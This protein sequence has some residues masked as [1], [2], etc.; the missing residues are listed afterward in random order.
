[1]PFW[2]GRR[3]KPWY[4]RWRRKRR[5]N[6]YKR[7]R[8]RFTRRRNRKTFRR[9]RKRKRKVRRKKKKITI[10]QWQPESIRKCTIKGYSTLVLGAEGRQSFCWTN[11]ASEYIQPKAP[12][13]G[14]FGCEAITLK[15]LYQEERRHNNIWTETNNYKDLCRYT[16]CQIIL[17]RHPT[18]DFV[19]N[20]KISPP[21]DIDKFTYTA[22]QPQNLLLARHHKVILSQKKTPN[23][24]HYVKIKIKCPKLMTTKWFFQR[25][26]CK[27]PLVQLQASAAD[28]GH[29]RIGPLSQSQMITINFLNAQFYPEPNW[30]VALN[31]PWL[32]VA[33]IS[34]PLTVKY[35]NARGETQTMQLGNNWLETQAGYYQSIN[36]NG[37]WFDARLLNAFEIHGRTGQAQGALP[38]AVARYNPNEDTGEG[39]SVYLISLTKDSYK[40]PTATPNYV[41]RGLPLW[42]A[43]FG[44]RDFIQY[45]SKDKNIMNSHMFVVKCPAIKRLSTTA[46]QTYYP[47]V[48]PEFIAGKLPFDEYLDDNQKKLWY[49]TANRQTTTINAL[50]ESG[51][52]IPKLTNIKE[53]TWELPYRYKFFFK[54]GGPQVTDKDVDDP[55]TQGFYPFPNSNQKNVQVA[56]PETQT[57][58]TMFH[59]WDYRRGIITQTALKRM[60][61][62]ISIDS[63]LQTIQSEPQRKR[64]KVT[65]EL[66]YNKDKEEE[67]KTCLLSLCEEN[68]CQEQNQDLHLL[69]QQQQQQQQLLKS[70]LLK[71][72]SELKKQQRCLQ[73]QTGHLE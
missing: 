27:Y 20:Y 3:R 67:I 54:W 59:D 48:D 21:F 73:L 26:F 49:P 40:E 23:K 32:P 61:E 70:N 65:K 69:I 51:P 52:Y 72:L 4:G 44:F 19:F 56:D 10:Q 25:D 35:K 46:E 12:G 33:T 13:G 58:E 64:K 31:K 62:N 63:D 16:G 43:F 39:N 18:V 60:S 34:I 55:E 50:V 38:I 68:T 9:G 41:I 45:T 15:W 42:M 22:I 57:P 2:W 66:P 5:Y 7:R 30:A 14:G 24:R 28:M 17:Y 6:P 53:S 37:G 47:I 1:M 36:Y 8:R 11:Q 29:P 71:L